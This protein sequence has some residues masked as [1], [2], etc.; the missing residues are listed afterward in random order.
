MLAE[1]SHTTL[2]S[3]HKTWSWREL[4][5]NSEMLTAGTSHNTIICI[6]PGQLLSIEQLVQTC[7]LWLITGDSD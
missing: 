3:F 5:K 6:F 7:I 4:A 2:S 1:V